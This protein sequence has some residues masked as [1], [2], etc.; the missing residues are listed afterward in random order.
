MVDKRSEGRE[1]HSSKLRAERAGRPGSWEAWKSEVSGRRSGDREKE[2]SHA[3]NREEKVRQDNRI[4][5]IDGIGEG[6][7]RTP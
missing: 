6:S 7:L 4:D 3:E 2:D 5:G 1:A